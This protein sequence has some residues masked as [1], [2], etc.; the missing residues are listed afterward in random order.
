MEIQKNHDLPGELH[1]RNFDEK[2]HLLSCLNPSLAR[3]T[4]GIFLAMDSNQRAQSEHLKTKARIY[5][6]Q[7]RT[8]VIYKIHVWYSYTAAFSKILEYPMEEIDISYEDWEDIIKLFMG[9]LLNSSGMSKNFPRKLIFSSKKYNGLDIK[10]PF[11]LL[12]SIHNPHTK[13]HE[14]GITG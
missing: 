12:P 8:G 11:Y 14:H 7:L 9:Q 2:I 13:N 4:L 6:E 10:Y 1:A 3:E 5:L